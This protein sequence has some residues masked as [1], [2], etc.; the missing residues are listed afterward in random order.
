MWQDVKFMPLRPFVQHTS[1]WYILSHKQNNAK[2]WERNK[3]KTK[4][5]KTKQKKQTKMGNN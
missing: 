4:E 2:R 3:N 5:T 1:E